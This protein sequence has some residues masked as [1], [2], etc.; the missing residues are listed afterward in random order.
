[1]NNNSSKNN[2]NQRIQQIVKL[3]QLK[4]KSRKKKQGNLRSKINKKI[5]NSN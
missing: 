4:I 1:M 3:H 2:N 5:N